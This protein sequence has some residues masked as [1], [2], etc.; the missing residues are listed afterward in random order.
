MLSRASRALADKD[1]QWTAE[2]TD[3]V[4]A[5]DEGNVDAKRLKAAALS[6]LG[7]PQTSALAR[8]YY[9]SA[10][11]YLLRDLTAR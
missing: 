8:N 5:I 9:L 11:Q 7:Q 6:E 1:F 3:C 10:S 4:L 2:L